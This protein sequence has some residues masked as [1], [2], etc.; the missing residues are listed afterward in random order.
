[1]GELGSRADRARGEMVIDH[2]K[3]IDRFSAG[4]P[5]TAISLA[6]NT[7]IGILTAIHGEQPR[8][9]IAHLETLCSG[10]CEGIA[11]GTIEIIVPANDEESD[12]ELPQP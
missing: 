6:M 2:L 3:D 11:D 1:M 7:L 12:G 5:N 8:S 4:D 9:V 10:V